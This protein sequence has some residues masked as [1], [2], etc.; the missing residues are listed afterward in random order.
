V[1]SLLHLSV[2][3]LVVVELLH[4]PGRTRQMVLDGQPW[5]P[6]GEFYATDAYN[7]YAAERIR[8][9][10]REHP[11]RPFFLYLAHT[12]PPFPLH[13]LPEDIARYEER[14]AAGWDRVRAEQ[15]RRMRE[16]GVIDERYAL[17]PRPDS[18]PAWEDADGVRHRPD[19]N[20]PRADGGPRIPRRE[21]VARCCPTA[22]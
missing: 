20:G 21:A 14:Y 8:E 15:H 22:A 3:A 10:R 9:H 18:V 17:P 12:A 1:T 7:D 5:R 19:A 16:I 6:T 4:E 13:A 2:A 11:D